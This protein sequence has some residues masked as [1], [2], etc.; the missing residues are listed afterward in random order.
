MN[1]DSVNIQ[2]QSLST[3]VGTVVQMHNFELNKAGSN[4]TEWKIFGGEV[5]KILPAI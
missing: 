4:E 1:I 3:N 2:L 5:R